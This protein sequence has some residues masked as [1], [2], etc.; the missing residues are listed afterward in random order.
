MISHHACADNKNCQSGWVEQEFVYV[1][2]IRNARAIC[3]RNGNYQLK[4]GA[5]L[6]NCTV[7]IVAQVS[8]WQSATLL[9]I[10][11]KSYDLFQLG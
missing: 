2:S 10:C 3:V 6:M 1:F 7:V 5:L 4:F 8:A 9:Q 11:C